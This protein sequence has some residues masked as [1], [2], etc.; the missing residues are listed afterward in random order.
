[1]IAPFAHSALPV[2]AAAGPA[3]S[4]DARLVQ[5]GDL[6]GAPSLKLPTRAQAL[7]PTLAVAKTSEL[8]PV[9]DGRPRALRAGW[10]LT[11]RDRPLIR[12]S[13]LGTARTPTGPP[14]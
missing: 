1:M 3:A 6:G 7:E 14:G 8:S 10:A 4:A 2:D 11:G 5:D 13:A 9:A 12:R